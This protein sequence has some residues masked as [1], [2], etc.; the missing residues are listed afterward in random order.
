LAFPGRLWTPPDRNNGPTTAE[1]VLRRVDE[2]LYQGK[3]A[4]RNRLTVSDP[5]AEGDARD[6]DVQMC[7]NPEKADTLFA[8]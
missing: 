3:R 2:A 4:G 7:S 8:L 5:T 6:S 1:I